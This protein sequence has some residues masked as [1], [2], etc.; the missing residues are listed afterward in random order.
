MIPSSR[1]SLARNVSSTAFWG[2]TGCSSHKGFS[3]EAMKDRLRKRAERVKENAEEV[4]KR[5]TE[6][7]G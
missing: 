4:K 7:K 2:M 5:Y 6:I 3:D 1:L